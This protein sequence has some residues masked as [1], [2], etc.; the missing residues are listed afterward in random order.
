MPPKISICVPT[1]NGAKYLRECLDDILA[2]SFGDFEVV[3]ADDDSRDETIDIIEE[4]GTRDQRISLYR[5]SHNLGLVE[6]WN[7]CAQLAQGE[8]VK[9]VFQDDRI[10][11]R[12]L[13]VLLKESRLGVPLTVCQ[14]HFIYE[15]VAAEEQ[16]QYERYLSE[17]CLSALFPEGGFLSSFR[18]CRA[19][20]E[21]VANNFVGEPSAV[22]LH[23]SVRARFGGFNPYFVQLCD[24]EYWARM[25]C[26]DGLIFVPEVLASFRVHAGSKTAANKGVREFRTEL[27]DP[28]LLKYEF[29]YAPY[30][31]P[32]RAV[33][34]KLGLNLKRSLAADA[35]RTESVA[36]RRAKDVL[37]P[38]DQPITEW[39]SI[40]SVYPKLTAS[41][42]ARAN[43]L[44]DDLDRRVFW[45][46]RNSGVRFRNPNSLCPIILCLDV[47]PDD[48]SI[49]HGRPAAWRGFEVISE[50]FLTVRPQL[51]SV[52]GAPVH[53]SWMLRMDPQVA[54]NHGTADWLVH[55]YE[56]LI[57]EYNG[58]GDE[59]GLHTRAQGWDGARGCWIADYQNDAWVDHCVTTSFKAFYARLGRNCDSF[60]FVGGGMSN[61]TVMLLE[62]LGA[63]FDLSLQPGMHHSGP[64]SSAHHPGDFMA[65]SLLSSRMPY[66]PT[67]HDFTRPDSTRREGLW[68]I[69]LSSGVE[70]E[71]APK[72][73]EESSFRAV[74]LDRPP[75]QFEWLINTILTSLERPYLALAISSTTGIKPRHLRNLKM[76][77][78]SLLMHPLAD[79]FAFCTPAETLGTLGYR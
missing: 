5:N 30:Y 15:D 76:N 78:S 1:Y 68:I 16:V 59:I 73:N 26:H 29:A 41:T 24:F 40:L 55:H 47:E 74:E 79:R 37:V 51:A 56:A 36:R 54:E 44:N 4:Y 45:R 25:A 38:D 70:K 72:Q 12:C 61:R 48:G 7:R 3:I 53:Y 69:P 20:L 42:Y 52:T 60:R 65:D 28:L 58:A 21:R 10:D 50:L 33:A 18:F 9:F 43:K 39:R 22:M 49:G 19:A 75:D 66:Q 71:P 77:F 31:A 46:F 27:V 34:R 63:R 6:N 32:M 64:P 62:E 67:L 13:E 2:Q 17:R 57:Q 35:R 11:M 14:R 23:Q 8:W